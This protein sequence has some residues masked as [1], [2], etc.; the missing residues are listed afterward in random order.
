MFKGS[1]VALVTPFKDGAVDEKKLAE[2]VEWQISEGTDGLVPCGTTGESATLS[3][4]EHA[5]VIEVV[6][7]AVRKRVPVI[8]GAG[9][10]STQEAIDLTQE[11]K[12]LGADAVLSVNPY[13]NRPTAEGLV[14]HF[15][16][17]AK[18]VDI[19]MVLYNIPSRTGVN[20][21][22]ATI[23]Q[24]A[25]AH[26]N[27]VGVKEAT[28]VMDQASEIRTLTPASFCIM[29]GDDSLTVPLMA[30]GAT[31]VISVA[32]NL[33]PKAIADLCKALLENDY[34]KARAMHEKQFPLIKALFIETN[35]APIKAAMAE[36]GLLDDE[37]LRG[38]MVTVTADTRKKL[39]KAMK[40][41]GV[42]AVAV[43][44]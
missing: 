17:I 36:A 19:P 15:S 3:H 10:N 38:P 18:S 30:I 41:Y 29:S 9:S 43:K 1:Y 35:P 25:K 14:F 39:V 33:I 11:A 24:L 2:L 5:R 34:T 32:A 13:Y 7:K 42:S 12:N 20:L 28:G 16:S 22:P 23:A 26:R 27:I 6:C 4:R 37:S 31:G 44:P 8:A 40:D 21:M